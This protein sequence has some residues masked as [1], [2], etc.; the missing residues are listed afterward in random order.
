VQGDGNK[1]RR[2]LTGKNSNTVRL[3]CH[4]RLLGFPNKH[5]YRVLCWNCNCGRTRNGGV[6]PHK[7]KSTP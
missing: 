2:R 6:C 5:K 3:F 1:E 7:A 4:L